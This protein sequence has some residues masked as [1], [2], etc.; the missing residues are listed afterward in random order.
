MY[1]YI[2]TMN[3]IQIEELVVVHPL[4]DHVAVL[5]VAS[6]IAC[7]LIKYLWQEV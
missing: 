6:L 5:R 3:L 4:E 1:M 7:T 2:I